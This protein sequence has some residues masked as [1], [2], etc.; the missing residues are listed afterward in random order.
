MAS[1][2]SGAFLCD[3]KYFWKQKT[4]FPSVRD[5]VPDDQPEVAEVSSGE[6]RSLMWEHLQALGV[7]D[8]TEGS[9]L[10]IAGDMPELRTRGESHRPCP[11]MVC[12]LSLELTVVASTSG[13]QL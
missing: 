8:K 6:T 2:L 13:I 10:Q 3:T 9:Q 12:M 7:Q 1:L 4:Y 5:S 11:G